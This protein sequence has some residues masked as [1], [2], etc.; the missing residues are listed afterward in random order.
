MNSQRRLRCCLLGH[1]LKL[2]T[3]QIYNNLTKIQHISVSVGLIPT[4]TGKRRQVEIA[5]S[6]SRLTPAHTGK[7]FHSLFVTPHARLIPAHTGK[8]LK[9]SQLRSFE[10]AH[11]RAYGENG[12]QNIHLELGKGSSPRIRGKLAV[13]AVQ[14]GDEGLIPAHTGK[15]KRVVRDPLPIGAH[16]RA[17]GENRCMPAFAV[18]FRGSSPRIRGKRVKRVTVY[19]RGG[20]IPAH[21]GK[22]EADGSAAMMVGAHPRA[23]GENDSHSPSSL[24]DLGSS[25]RIR[26]KRLFA[27]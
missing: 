14:D 27:G 18:S 17:Y 4:H 7:S 23:Y 15:T 25:P 10:W 9:Y 21:T 5:T 24:R 2:G 12:L 26:G 1:A 3:R 13:F 8:T 11:P 20:L 19:R 6:A 16:P 22:T